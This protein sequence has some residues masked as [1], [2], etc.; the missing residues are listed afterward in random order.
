[1]T[2]VNVFVTTCLILA[3]VLQVVGMFTPEWRRFGAGG[4]Q[5]LLIND[6]KKAQGRKSIILSASSAPEYI[7]IVTAI[8]Y[9]LCLLYCSTCY[10]NSGIK[11]DVKTIMIVLALGLVMPLV[12]LPLDLTDPKAE[13]TGIKK[14][15]GYSHF[16]SWGS[17]GLT[18]VILVVLLASQ[19]TTNIQLSTPV[20]SFS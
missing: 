19:T 13:S 15:R 11:C 8:G 17:A 12:G 7:L 5:G 6:S 14:A 4:T 2:A 16:L 9:L 3:I 10:N 20:F 18:A 1:M